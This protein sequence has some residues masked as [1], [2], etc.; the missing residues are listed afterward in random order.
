MQEQP[1]CGHHALKYLGCEA[2]R[3]FFRSQGPQINHGTRSVLLFN[4]GQ[5]QC[6]HRHDSRV[7]LQAFQE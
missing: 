6:Q 4:F 1:L 3:R 2:D 5:E 7:A